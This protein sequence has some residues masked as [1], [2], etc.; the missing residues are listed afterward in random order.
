MNTEINNNLCSPHFPCRQSIRLPDYDYSLAG[1]YFVTICTHDHQFLFGK[2]SNSIIQLSSIGQIVRSCCMEIPKHFEFAET[3][4]SVI[5]PNHI[6]GIILISRIVGTRHAVS[7][8]ENSTGETFGKPVKHSLPTIIRSFKSAVTRLVNADHGRK[9]IDLWQ[10]GYY[11]HV[12][13]G[14]EELVRIGEYILGNPQKWEADRENQFAVRREKPLE[15][16][17]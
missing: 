4:A 7:E 17:Y 16:E 14:E 6:H 13:R 3:P 12:I 15:F 5:M 2:I 10:K 11:E 9:R 8:N 1:A